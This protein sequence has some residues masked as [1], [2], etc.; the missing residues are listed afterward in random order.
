MSKLWRKNARRLQRFLSSE[1]A[2]CR[3][4]VCNYHATDI[5]KPLSLPLPTQARV[6]IAGSGTV[7]NSVAYH[8]VINGWND[9]LVLE[10]NR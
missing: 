1:G 6:V 4:A 10:Q 9:V 2:F 3:V 5:N 7:A 8:L